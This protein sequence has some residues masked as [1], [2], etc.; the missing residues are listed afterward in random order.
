M[1]IVLSG[2]ETNNKGAELMLYAILQE[3]ERRFPDAEVY[4]PYYRIKQGTKYVHTNLKFK[5]TP[6]S[7]I[8]EK[9]NFLG[10]CPN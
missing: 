2:V 7:E 5:T 6:W 10:F 3:V 4:L 8:V 1:K 9:L